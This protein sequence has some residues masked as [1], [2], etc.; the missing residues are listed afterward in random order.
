MLYL[1]WILCLAAAAPGA[2]IS[3][4]WNAGKLTLHL[5]DGT[6]ELE[7]LSPVAFRFSRNWSDAIPRSAPLTH[8][9][10]APELED[11]GSTI[12]MRTKYLSVDLDRT[13][14]RLHIHS[15]ETQVADATLSREGSGAEVRIL[16][17]RDER[18]FGLM[19][20][21]GAKLNLRG[22]RLE[23]QHGFF[24]TSAGYGMFVR[25]PA[26]CIFDLNR[27]AIEAPGADSMEYV[28]YYGP[29][30]K[31]IL[32]QYAS[33]I[34]KN[35]VKAAALD[36]LSP[37]RLPKETQKLPAAPIQSWDAL[38]GLVRTLNNWSLSG[39][40]YPALDLSVFDGAPANLQR[41]AADLSMLLPIVYRGLESSSG[42]N[43]IDSATRKAW[44][45]YL[46]TYLR[47]AFDRGYPLIRP[48]PMQ[49]S[50]DANSDWQ[51]DV[52]MLG[53]EVLLAPMVTPG[54]RRRLELP[55][56]NWTDLRTNIEYHG[57]Q[58]IEVDA[59]P[60]RVPMF[61][62]NGWIV[63]LDAGTILGEKM[64]LHY[65]PSLGAEFFLWEPGID[66]NSQFHAA[67]AGDFVRVEIESQKPRTYEW[68][69][70][71]TKAAREVVEESGAYIK[72]DRREQLRP[73]AWW[74]D[75]RNNNL[76]L[77]LRAEA[78]SDRIVN[79]SF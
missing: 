7:W 58:T 43:G 65:F 73:G 5:D 8:G 44:T 34:S 38:A 32:E 67:P 40:P 71:H 3:R 12:T 28:F 21:A 39:V 53:D 70:H 52:F 18:I 26:D 66:D 63:P 25:S 45:P 31:E 74:H 16:L 37:D 56:G 14:L 76:H 50:R 1:C 42:E 55:R 61:V 47:E 10:I 11:V 78:G 23:R 72:V 19:G 17:A 13:D 9:K 46:L 22:E 62:R 79:I 36:L 48:L 60:G 54:A 49:F 51:A 29:T 59:P 4:D 20:G 27:G 41:R 2:V 35:E 77:M 15:G 30:A 33:L 57:Q 64:E 68:V 75:A 24:F 69:L 6:A